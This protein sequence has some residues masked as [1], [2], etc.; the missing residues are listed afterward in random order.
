MIPASFVL[1]DFAFLTLA[2]YWAILYHDNTGG[3]GPRK[4]PSDFRPE[5]AD[6]REIVWHAPQKLCKEKYFAVFL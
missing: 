3:G 5:G 6:R 4:P 1:I 2:E